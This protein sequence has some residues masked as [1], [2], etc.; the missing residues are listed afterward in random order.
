M[1]LL[2]ACLPAL[3]ACPTPTRP[4]PP[5]PPPCPP[6][7]SGHNHRQHWLLQA[8]KSRGPAPPRSTDVE[9]YRVVSQG[10]EGAGPRLLR[11][12][13][14]C[15]S[16]TFGHSVSLAVSSLRVSLA[17]SVGGS[18]GQADHVSACTMQLPSI[19]AV[20]GN[21]RKQDMKNHK[22]LASFLTP[23]IAGPN[24]RSV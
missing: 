24:N 19:P 6:L 5:P 8:L 15:D 13:P 4:P 14:S 3:P 23:D 22:D 9:Y 1:W 7:L 12:P 10:R 20:Y 21:Q 11:S 17:G 16:V 2:I 18:V